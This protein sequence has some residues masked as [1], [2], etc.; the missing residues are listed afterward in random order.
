[1]LRNFFASPNFLRLLR[2]WE[3]SRADG[4]AAAWGGNISAIPAELQP[5]LVIVERV[6]AERLIYRFVGSEN[7]SQFGRDPT[8]QSVREILSPEYAAYIED[9]IGITL[10]RAAPVFSSSV[11][12]LDTRVKST[13]RLVAPFA[14][15]GASKPT[16]IM[17][18]H[19]MGGDD[20]K[21]T[22]IAAPGSVVE[23]ERLMIA[24][25]PEMCARLEEAGRYHR[26]SRLT[27]DRSLAQ[28][29]V[30]IAAS[31]GAGILVPLEGFRT[32]SG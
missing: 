18:A 8:G 31:L 28:E 15:R 32:L 26:F 11:L 10:D 24:G 6:A 27:T 4:G 3:A 29:W 23:T 16:L 17:S 22:E 19:L 21:V 1:M 14:L 20:F 12:Y 13:G 30:K 5:R 7:V 9:I 2:F 25:V